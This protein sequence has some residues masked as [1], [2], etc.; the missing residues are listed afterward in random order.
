MDLPTIEGV[1]YT[2]SY[3]TFTI[4]H[5][6][7]TERA[8][9][10]PTVVN[11]AQ[12]YY[13]FKCYVNSIQMAEP[14]TATFH[15]YQDGV[16]KTVE[17]TYAVNDY[18]TSFE[19]AVTAGQITDGT[20]IDLVRALADYGHYVQPFL[21]SNN[22]WT[23]GTEHAVMNGANVYDETDVGNAKTAVAEK[24]I[25]RNVGSSQIAAVSYSL[26]LESETAIRIY[27]KM[28]DG[29]TGSVTATLDGNTVDCVKQKDGRYRIEISGI[30]A[31]KLD[32]VYDITVS[33]G[34]DCA[35]SV[36]ALSYVNTVLNSENDVFN[37]DTA[38][39][40]VTSLYNY[41]A[42]AMNYKNNPNA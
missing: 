38:H 28:Q 35:I 2:N 12:T 30:S 15:Y 24:A 23:L 22:G 3:M 40:A 20:T 39:Y 42:K 25:V 18:F 13:G 29:Y 6:T 1:D 34:G 8:E 5:G 21:A 33:A 19:N 10:D 26:N 16:E 27:L 17:K 32:D 11:R 14:I 37:N 36:S 4:P 7:C 31:H 41:Y 9:Y